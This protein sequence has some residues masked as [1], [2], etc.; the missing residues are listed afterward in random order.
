MNA[1]RIAAVLAVA[2]L[3]PVALSDQ[4]DANSDIGSQWIITLQ[5]PLPGG[6]PL[7]LHLAE[8]THRVVAAFGT[9]PKFNSRWHDV[10]DHKL[11]LDGGGLEGKLSLTVNPDPWVPKDGKP[12]ACSFTLQGR[13]KD[14]TISGTFTGTVGGK[15][16]K[17]TLTG[18][19]TAAPGDSRTQRYR[20]RFFQAL[21]MIAPARGRHGPNTNYALD[22]VLTCAL[23]PSGSVSEALLE[24]VVPDYRSYSA[25]VKSIAL[26]RTGARLTGT[27]TADID[28]G[29]DAKRIDKPVL[30]H[31]F[32]IDGLVIGETV[33]VRYDAQVADVH[34]KGI[35]AWGTV[36]R[37][38]A[39]RPG[40]SIATVR[41]HDG[42][43]K[44][45]PVIMTL[46][47]D[48]DGPIRGHA[49]A[50]GWNHQIHKV[51]TG[52]LTLEDGRL[53]GPLHITLDPDC[54]KDP[55]VFI[56]L[57]YTIDAKIDGAAMFGTFR[58]GMKDNPTSGRLTGHLRPRA[59]PAVTQETL[60]TA[61]F[62]LGWCLA[63]G[64]RVKGKK[65]WHHYA[66]ARL[67]FRNGKL[68][69]AEVYNPKDRSA[70]TARVTE[71]KLTVEGT[72][73]SGVLA[74]DAESAYVADGRYR[75]NL[76]GFLDGDRFTGLWRGT[77][78]GRPVLT[79]SAKL[80]GELSAQEPATRGQ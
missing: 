40:M 69:S 28:Y 57:D 8:S 18:E 80:Y 38:P 30:T 72:K 53:S 52:K 51:D 78:N 76:L 64:K 49:F 34:D 60:R 10:T 3:A 25:V 43:K 42:M 11:T 35:P 13:R 70:L 23:S 77:H 2:L 27:L 6:K 9:S 58:G 47:L 21:R 29:R 15:E 20:I 24:N 48:E 61:H 14:G 45:W 55:N 75:F 16:V 54:Y 1:S 59:A 12:I 67:T 66:D 68:V 46:L 50:S 74:F 17:G 37:E 32:T 4:P 5:S 33:A 31:T 22:M 56:D 7:R 62:R 36:S 73:V 26:K 63:G 41:L 39:P 44:S 79:K 65:G 19:P 71:A